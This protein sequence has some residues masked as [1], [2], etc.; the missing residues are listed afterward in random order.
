MAYCDGS[1]TYRYIVNVSLLYG[2]VAER[3]VWV[4]SRILFVLESSVPTSVKHSFNKISYLYLNLR[5]FQC[6][7]F[8]Y[9]CAWYTCHTLMI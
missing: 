5:L 1:A 6:N 3:N 7:Y 8:F 2:S 9:L 4:L